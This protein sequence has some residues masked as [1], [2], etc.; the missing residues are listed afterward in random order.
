LLY[1]RTAIPWVSIAT[2]CSITTAYLSR[3]ADYNR[4]LFR[5]LITGTV[6]TRIIELH[7]RMLKLPLLVRSGSFF[8]FFCLELVLRGS[9]FAV[10]SPPLSKRGNFGHLSV[11]FNYSNSYSNL[12]SSFQNEFL[13]RPSLILRILSATIEVCSS[14]SQP[15]RIPR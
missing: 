14:R 1:S 9:V 6:G 13:S 12:N 15:I 7:A 8:F 4:Y 10:R 11:S 3:R 5:F 2:L